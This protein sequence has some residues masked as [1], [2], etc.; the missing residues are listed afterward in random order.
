MQGPFRQLPGDDQKGVVHPVR[1]MEEV[2]VAGTHGAVADERIKVQ[3]LLPEVGPV[4]QD[5]YVLRELSGLLQ[6]E[7]LEQ[8]VEGA[9][10]PRKD[11]QGL[12]TGWCRITN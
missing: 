8:L 9:E 6:G 10:A 2:E 1:A 5:G 12:G 4:K 7:Q 3:H 11:D